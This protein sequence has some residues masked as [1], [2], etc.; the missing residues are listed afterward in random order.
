M[1]YEIYMIVR[2]LKFFLYVS[3]LEQPIGPKVLQDSCWILDS[4]PLK[5]LKIKGTQVKKVDVH[6]CW[7]VNVKDE[8]LHKEV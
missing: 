4:N 3:S 5:V 8:D 2:L 7:S 1:I 6:R